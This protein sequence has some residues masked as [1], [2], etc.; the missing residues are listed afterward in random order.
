MAQDA[1]SPSSHTQRPPSL[2]T[3]VRNLGL[4]YLLLFSPAPSPSPVVKGGPPPSPLGVLSHYCL[5]THPEGRV[6]G[7]A[8]CSDSPALDLTPYS[9]CVALDNFLR[10][11][12]EAGDWTGRPLLSPG[13][14]G[15]VT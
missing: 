4:V 5:W 1:A 3:R 10:S 15:K 6:V 11:V 12:W 8:L 9:R 7:W 14:S 2:R 13:L